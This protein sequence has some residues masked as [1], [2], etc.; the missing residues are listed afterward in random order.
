MRKILVVCASLVITFLVMG[1]NG[2][3]FDF[4]IKKFVG[5]WEFKAP[6]APYGYQNGT[7]NL[8]REKRVLKGTVTIGSYDTELQEVET[9]KN[10]LKC[11]VSVE[12]ERV[13]L[14][15]D[16]DKDS[17]EGVAMSS[18]GDIPMTGIRTSK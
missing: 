11:Y 17:F 4:G 9:L 16:F 8:T 14:K 7:I 12:G 10:E 2:N 18:E 6:D 5:V 3:T 1:F 13:Q 15:L